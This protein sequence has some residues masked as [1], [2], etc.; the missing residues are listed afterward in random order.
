MVHLL[1][2][3]SIKQGLVDFLSHAL[4]DVYGA[5]SRAQRP[6]KANP[7][8]HDAKISTYRAKASAHC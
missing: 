8:V 7:S 5:R 6:Q 4:L 2:V 3:L 1:D